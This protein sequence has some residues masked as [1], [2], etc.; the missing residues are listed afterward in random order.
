MPQIISS[1]SLCITASGN[2]LL[3]MQSSF[4]NATSTQGKQKCFLEVEIC[5]SLWLE[6]PLIYFCNVF[7]MCFRVMRS[8][9][10]QIFRLWCV[11][12]PNGSGLLSMWIVARHESQQLSCSSHWYKGIGE[13]AK[14]QEQGTIAYASNMRS[15]SST[16]T[17]IQ[18]LDG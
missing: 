7:T 8:K 14:T 2:E 9:E 5:Y 18:M 4:L 17:E 16:K 10:V 13:G 6:I 11:L 1:G 15:S 12:N 3:W